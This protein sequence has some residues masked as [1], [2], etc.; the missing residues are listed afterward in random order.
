MDE[1][2]HPKI[3]APIPLINC[4]YCDKSSNFECYADGSKMNNRVG[5]SVVIYQKDVELK[6]WNARLPGNC[7]VFQAE[8]KALRQG[9]IMLSTLLNRGDSISVFSDSS[10]ALDVM[11]GCNESYK[12]AVWTWH[13]MVELMVNGHHLQLGWIKAHVG[14]KGNERAD[15]LAKEASLQEYIVPHT[16]P[17]SSLKCSTINSLYHN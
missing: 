1:Q 10:T 11:S 8:L 16:I 4:E 14:H 3:V 5:A 2:N 13:K 15:L 12:D 9:V 17:N 7:T 6:T